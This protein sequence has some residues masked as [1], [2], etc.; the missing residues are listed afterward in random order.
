MLLRAL[1]WVS[2]IGLLLA[3]ES[4]TIQP[5]STRSGI[6]YFPIETGNFREYAVQDIS[7]NLLNEPDTQRYFI[8]EVVTDSFPGQGNEAIYRLERFSRFS[9]AEGWQLDSV[10][11]ARLNTQ[12]AVVVENNVPL[13]KLVFPFIS[14]LAWDGNA[15]NAKPNDRYELQSTPETL[16][17]EIESPIDTLLGQS[18]TVVQSNMSSLVNDSIFSETYVDEVGLFYKK[19]VDLAYCAEEDCLGQFIIDF[20]RDYRQTLIAYGKI[21]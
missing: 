21:D 19:S 14:N 20:G 10:W 18:I 5:S 13:I 9:T 16:L 6:S 15:L 7:Y 12:R 4:E 3:C 11:T 1:L 2:I 8:R 17:E